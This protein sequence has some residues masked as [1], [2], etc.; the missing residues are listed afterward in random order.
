[1]QQQTEG[2]NLSTFVAPVCEI[3]A[4]MQYKAHNK[5][6]SKQFLKSLKVVNTI[7]CI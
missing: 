5:I 1:M 3:Y 2:N 7:F 4:A 6:L